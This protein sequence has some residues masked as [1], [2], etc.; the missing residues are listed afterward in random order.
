VIDSRG[1]SKWGFLAKTSNPETAL[2]N[3]LD[4][5]RM[6]TDTLRE[7]TTRLG[8]PAIEVDATITENDLFKRVTEVFRL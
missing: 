7:E 2:C 5:D 4:R 3:L 8:L 1:G 6:F